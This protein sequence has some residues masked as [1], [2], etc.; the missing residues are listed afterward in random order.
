[1]AAT[2]IL[3]IRNWQDPRSG[4]THYNGDAVTVLDSV[5]ARAV[6]SG[7]AVEADPQA[8]EAKTVQQIEEVA[9]QAGVDLSGKKTKK[10]KINAIEKG[11]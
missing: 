1:M 2:K 3:F 4:L 9:E 11:E 8:L 10:E 5:A 7:A 6:S